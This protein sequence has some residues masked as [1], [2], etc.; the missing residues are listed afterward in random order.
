MKRINVIRELL[1]TICKTGADGGRGE[2]ANAHEGF[3]GWYQCAENP[4][5]DLCAT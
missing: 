1:D 5:M 4:G 2:I 3:A